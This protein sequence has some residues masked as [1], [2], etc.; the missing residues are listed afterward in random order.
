MIMAAREVRGADEAR[1]IVENT[2]YGVAIEIDSLCVSL[3]G[4]IIETAAEAQSSIFTRQRQE[5]AGERWQFE[6]GKLIDKDLHGI[7]LLRLTPSQIVL[8]GQFIFFIRSCCR[9]MSMVQIPNRL[10][11][12]ALIHF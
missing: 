10:C 7:Y 2:E 12:A 4:M 9:R 3:D 6:A 5:M 1:L 8:C 11:S